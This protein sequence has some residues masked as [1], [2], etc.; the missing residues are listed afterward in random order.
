MDL[1]LGEWIV[2]LF[3]SNEQNRDNYTIIIDRNILISAN[4]IIKL[5]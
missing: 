2:I 5:I 3:L 4:F 1:I